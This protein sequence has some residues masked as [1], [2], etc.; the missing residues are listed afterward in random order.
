MSPRHKKLKKILLTESHLK[1]RLQSGGE[2]AL[3][4]FDL[5]NGNER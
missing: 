2:T 5:V 3:I 4:A 1:S